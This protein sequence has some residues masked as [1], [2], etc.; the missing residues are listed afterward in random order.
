MTSLYR[1]PVIGKGETPIEC[2]SRTGFCMRSK[3]AIKVKK[4]FPAARGTTR[5]RPK[6]AN[7]HGQTGSAASTRWQGLDGQVDRS[8]I[9]S[10]S[11]T[12][13]I[14]KPTW[15]VSGGNFV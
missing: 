15:N 3:R 6:G 5:P 7:T 14:R 2:I 1:S 11:Q 8:A 10:R 9:Y 12:K 13:A 4:T